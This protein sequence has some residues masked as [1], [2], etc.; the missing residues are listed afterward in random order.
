MSTNAREPIGVIGTGYVGL[1]TA[2]GFAELGSDVYCIDIDEAKIEGLKQGRIPIWEPGLAELVERHRDRLHFSTDLADALEHARLLFVAVGT[3]PTYSGDADLSAVHAVVDAMP[4]SDRHALVMK[5]TVPCG[6]GEAIKRAFREQGKEGFRYVSCPEFLKE[7]SA[8]KD[9]LEPDRVVIGDDGDWAGDAVA[10]LY[11]PLDAPVVR[12]DIKSA[13]MVKLASNA[14]LATKISFINEIANVCEE[15]GADVVEVARGMG[16]DDRI[17]PKFLQAGIGFGGSCFPKDVSALKQLAGNSGYHFQLLNAVIEVNELQKRRV[18]SKLQKYLGTLVGKEIALLGLAF[19]PNTDDMREASSLVLSARLQAAGAKVRAYDPVAEDGG[20]QDAAGRRVRCLGRGGRGGRRRRRARHRV[21]RVPRARPARG[22][23]EHARHAAGRRPQLPRSRRRHGRRAHLRGRRPADAGGAL[24]GRRGRGLM[25]A[26][27]LAGGEGTRLRPLTSTV[28]KPVVPLVDRPFIAFMLDWL[29]THGVEDI[30]ISCGHM[31]SGVRNVLGD[32]SAFGVQLRYVEEPT[33][34]GTGGALKYAES[35]LDDR[36]FMLNGD[37]LTDIDLSAQ[38]AQHEQTGATATLALTPVE[39]PTNYGLVRTGD[40]GAVTEFVEKPSYDQID[41][42]NISAGAYVLERS[43]LD[44]LEADQPAS[45]ERDV[46]PQLVGNG[47][48]GCVSENYW[49]DIGTPERYLEATFDILEGTVGTAFAERAGDGYLVVE[50]S[51]E[52][53]GRII[54]SALVE[55]GC[56]IADGARV[57]GRVVLES[58]V[59]VGPNTVIER[60]VVMRGAEIGANCTLSGCIVGGG[61]RIGDNTHITGLSVLGEGVTVGADNVLAN[62]ARL[63]PGVELPDG[64]IR[65]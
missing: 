46:F 42:R 23:R 33:P 45:I 54:P 55:S 24:V 9:F 10:E 6:T 22:G 40:D 64:A 4:A 63:F 62:G 52:S 18:M 35:L 49:L 21:A 36:F 7:G 44:L 41:T 13:E 60:S 65:F 27:I 61:V 51:V 19:K 39:D 43:V 47:L 38:L 58:G 32:G 34:L 29:R 26:L 25:Q 28:P 31:A 8:V 56:R 59:M 5:S 48:Y 20:A 30:V 1:V 50:Q 16:L 3:P 53:E 14:F 15:T 57:G 17:G 37:V 11:A 2:A 12:T